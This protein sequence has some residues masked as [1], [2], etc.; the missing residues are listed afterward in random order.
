MTDT[1]FLA[2]QGLSC[3][4][5]NSALAT[6]GAGLGGWTVTVSMVVAVRPSVWVVV[7]E[8]VSVMVWT[9]PTVV[10]AV[11]VAV[12]VTTVVGVAAVVTDGKMPMHEQA[13]E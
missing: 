11:A 7:W 4:S 9:A 1:A 13:E 3:P 10:V 6:V 8:T 2:V 5:S 12:D